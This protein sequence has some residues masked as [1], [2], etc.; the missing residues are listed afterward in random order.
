ML[1]PDA[2]KRVPTLASDADMKTELNNRYL[3]DR[4]STVIHLLQTVLEQSPSMTSG[5]ENHP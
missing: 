3:T 5:E 2:P 1:P 4:K